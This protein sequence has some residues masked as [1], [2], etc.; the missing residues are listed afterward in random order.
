MRTCLGAIISMS[1]LLECIGM[2][3]TECSTLADMAAE[4][5][6]VVAALTARFKHM[7]DPL[8]S[9]GNKVV[10]RVIL[11]ALRAK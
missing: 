7:N 2:R 10:G 8:L 4:F 6:A 11:F 5:T 9:S 1:S 3:L